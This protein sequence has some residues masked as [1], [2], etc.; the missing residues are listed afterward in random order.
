M[1]HNLELGPAPTAAP[2]Q[3]EDTESLQ[4]TATKGPSGAGPIPGLTGVLTHLQ[5]IT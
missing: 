3:A 2:A 5:S 4:I 1:T